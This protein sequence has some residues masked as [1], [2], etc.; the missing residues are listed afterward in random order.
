MQPKSTNLNKTSGSIQKYFSQEK[1]PENPK[2][3]RHQ[4]MLAEIK[5]TKGGEESKMAVIRN[6]Q[7][8]HITLSVFIVTRM[9][10][11]ETQIFP[12]VG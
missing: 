9:I 2:S 1:T 10:Q 12:Q 3:G 8:Q 5:I 6:C 7:F 11:I 4:A